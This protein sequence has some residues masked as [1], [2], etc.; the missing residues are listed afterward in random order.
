MYDDYKTATDDQ[1][2]FELINRFF[3]PGSY[4]YYCIATYLNRPSLITNNPEAPTIKFMS[5]LIEFLIKSKKTT[6]D[7]KEIALIKGFEHTYKNLENQILRYDL[8]SLDQIQL[9]KAIQKV[10]LSLLKDIYQVLIAQPKSQKTLSLYIEIKSKLR[11]LL[12]GS[13]GKHTNNNSRETIE[14]NSMLPDDSLVQLSNELPNDAIKDS[15]A[16]L[17]K[18]DTQDL[19]NRLQNTPSR[20]KEPYSPS[21]P[22]QENS[23]SFEINTSFKEFKATAS[24]ATRANTPSIFSGLLAES[25][26]SQENADEIIIPGE[27]DDEELLKLIQEIDSYKESLPL[28]NFVEIKEMKNTNAYDI[29]LMQNIASPIQ[30]KS[31]EKESKQYRE[32]KLESDK[33]PGIFFDESTTKIFQQEAVLY[34]KILANAITQLKDDEKIQSALEDIE[35]ASSSLKHLAQ[36]FGMEKLALLPELME[37]ISSLSN[38]HVIKPPDQIMLGIEDGINLIQEFDVNKTDHRA[39]FM[40]ILMVLKEYYMKILNKTRKFPVSF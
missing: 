2:Y 30:T 23:G 36:K 19:I 3:N 5:Q 22:E 39:K 17:T 14:P 26:R 11:T 24:R 34:Y 16:E 13:N 21:E 20:E 10:A 28:K 1:F 40:S 31:D 27:D 4:F 37:S 7:L 35:L 6:A 25:N 32:E 33:E 8:K 9:K 29:P 38:K 18:E 15:R 12:N